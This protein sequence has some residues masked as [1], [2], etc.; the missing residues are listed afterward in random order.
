MTNTLT[1]THTPDIPALLDDLSKLTPEQRNTYY[2]RVCNSLGLNPLTR[3]FQYIVLNGR[4]TLY[5]TRNATDQLCAIH[6]ISTII[7][8]EKTITVE[9]GSNAVQLYIVKCKAFTKE[10]ETTATGVV[11]LTGTAEQIANAMMRAETKAKRRAVLSLVGLS[12]LDETELD[13]LANETTHP[14]V[15]RARQKIV[16]FMQKPR[17]NPEHLQSVWDALTHLLAQDTPFVISHLFAHEVGDVEDLA[18]A[19]ANWLVAYCRVDEHNNLHPEA[20]EQFRSLR[21]FLTNRE[22]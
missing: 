9:T 12:F 14:L 5:A 13:T 2:L 11:V 8:D 6:N 22:V 15:A 19:E 17:P 1:T 20:V 10:R 7:L 18:D 3:P 4:L 21:E 16:N